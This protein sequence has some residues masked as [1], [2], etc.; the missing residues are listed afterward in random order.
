[1]TSINF[2][3]YGDQIYGLT[4]KYLTEYISPEIIKEDFTT[5]FKSGKLSYENISTKKQIEIK[6]QISLNE[7]NIEKIDIN[8]PNETDNLSINLN[9]VKAIINLFEINNDDI[10]KILIEERKGLIDKFM[11]FVIKQIEKK[12]SSKS[13]IEGLIENFVNRAI[14]GLSLDLN[15]IELILKYKNHI[16]SFVIEKINYDEDNGIKLNNISLLFGEDLNKKEII[17]KFSINIEI[18][19]KEKKEN[20][21]I[22]ENKEENNLELINEKIK[23]N[24]NENNEN[25]ESNNVKNEENKRNIIN[26][27]MSNFEF[28]L[29][30]SIFYSINDILD[31]FNNTEYQ[32]LFLR[33]KKLIQF[34]RPKQE[35]E[36]KQEEDKEDN[37]INKNNYMSRWYYA[38]KTVIKLQKYIGHKKDYIFDLIESSQIKIT[39][40]FLE[41]NLK[42]KDI[43]LPNEIN[44]LKST[45]EKVEKQLLENKKGGGITQA[46]SFFFGGGD[47]E[48]K[49]LTEEEKKELNNIYTDDY[50]MKYLL[51]LYETQNTDSNPLKEKI[52]KFINDINIKINVEKIELILVNINEKEN[53]NK[54]NL[55]I[56]DI[57]INFNLINKKYDF[58]LDINDIGTLLNESLFSNRVDNTNYLIQVKKYPNNELIKLNLGFHNIVLNEEIFIFILTYFYSLKI[59]KRFKLFHKNDYNSK[60]NQNEITPEGN[61][62]NN[63]VNNT[64]VD[65]FKLFENFSISHIPS[66]SLLNKDDNKIEFNLTNYSLNKN[67]LSF[68]INI[69]DSFGTILDD[70]TFNIKRERINNVQKFQ[71]YLDEALNIILSKKSTFF[72]FITYLK[73]KKILETIIKKSKNKNNEEKINND[74]NNYDNKEE[75]INLFCF[76]FIEYKNVDIDFN[77]IL[78]DIMLNEINIEIN[79]KKCKSFLSLNNLILKY[80][81]KDLIFKA[82]KIEIATDYLSTIT[83]YFLDFKSKDFD[84]Y[85]KI[86]ENDLDINEDS[87]NIDNNLLIITYNKNINEQINNNTITTNYNLKISDIIK[88][89]Q[90]EI[91]IIALAI[92]IE[93]NN[94]CIGIGNIQGNNNIEEPNIINASIDNAN[95]YIEKNNNLQEK[96]NIIN[97]NK[98]ILINYYLDTELIK[99]KID[100]PILNIFKNIF[101]T[102]F[103]DILFLLNQ[104]DWDVIICKTQIEILN[105]SIRFSIFNFIINNIYISNF[106][107]KSIDTFYLKINGFLTKNEKNI[108]IFEEQELAVDYTMKSKKE[109]YLYFKFNNIKINISQNDISFFISL[110]DSNDK[111]EEQNNTIYKVN[112][113]NLISKNSESLVMFENENNNNNYLEI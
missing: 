10:E 74:N 95:L 31:L 104:V 28:E 91:N 46:F 12:E 60:I 43:L 82:E 62:D 19:P 21:N 13:F 16:L 71:F 25:K 109:D 96:F 55:F 11:A 106:D 48:K 86:I 87:I 88:S 37:N 22:E 36:D 79:E 101:M 68:T 38:I 112:N 108:N 47:N 6:P 50:I 39:K 24:N 67:L 26:I 90:L 69:Q 77:N 98:I 17:N 57:N 81:N 65:D 40:K 66:L 53:N 107:G 61:K 94:V 42:I 70:Y 111:D 97:I 100:S 1:M 56:K 29:N 4:Q 14:N 27:A 113:M 2:R 78:V 99:L 18:N 64:D 59:K 93:E 33:Y 32:K 54:C 63:I 85:E 45:K 30:Q 35:I 20:I 51:G 9:N 76:N 89:L 83:L 23:E 15:N 44:L 41:D 102:I 75:N 49:E 58:E 103:N 105:L 52:N 8:I 7:L 72:L 5:Q 34:H 92:K 84:Q 80:E 73:L 3:L 110:F